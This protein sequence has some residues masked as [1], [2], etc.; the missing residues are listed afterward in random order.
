ML[1][2]ENFG[3]FG[4]NN[5]FCPYVRLLI[6]EAFVNIASFYSSFLV[7]LLVIN[8]NNDFYIKVFN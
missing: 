4:S 8:F 1:N 2:F 6:Y 5:L 3:C 7:I